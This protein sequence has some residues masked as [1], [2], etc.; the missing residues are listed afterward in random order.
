[1]KTDRKDM[2]TDSVCIWARNAEERALLI[3]Y[4]RKTSQE[5]NGALHMHKPRGEPYS[6]YVCLRIEITYRFVRMSLL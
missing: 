1:M 5:A 4:P 3:M 6:N 2:Y